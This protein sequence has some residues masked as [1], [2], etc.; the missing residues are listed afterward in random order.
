MNEILTRR[1]AWLKELFPAGIDRLWCP[2]LTHYRD[3]GTID[4]DRMSAHLNHIVPWVKGLLIPGS[5]GD[6]WELNGEETLQVADFA[7]RQARKYKLSILLGVL[8][9]DVDTMT[10]TI[11][12]LL[13]LIVPKA[14]ATKKETVEAL[15]AAGVCGFTVCP[16]RGKTLTQADIEAG[17]SRIF[18]LGWPVALYQLPQVT[19]NETAPETFERFVRSRS[20]LIFFK[21]SSGNDRIAT[22]GIDKGGVFLV[23]GAEGDYA[24]WLKD[25]GGPYDGFLLST[26]N[27]FARELR[28]VIDGLEKGDAEK[29]GATSG[30]LTRTINEVFGLVQSLPHGNA[31]TNANKA[32]DHFLAFG[33]AAAGRKGPM[34]HAGVR[35]PDEVVSGT[36][37]VLSR[38]GLM[39]EKGYLE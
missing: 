24:R 21:D 33:P 18:D 38:F 23:R 16:P 11:S 3:D 14:G 4:F 8:K 36:G 34:L 12:D 2:P 19:E 31:F 28:A 29:A 7:I 17:L 6:G 30:K 9:S 5:T 35:I 37:A 27:C 15:K 39:P 20:N 25:A 10:R 26:A 1:Q 13:A 32:I 22:A